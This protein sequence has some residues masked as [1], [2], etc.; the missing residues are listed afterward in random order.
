[1]IRASRARDRKL[2]VGSGSPRLRRVALGAGLA[3]ALAGCSSPGLFP[4]SGGPTSDQAWRTDGYGLVYAV[5]AGKLRTF[6]TTAVGCTPADTLDPVG[7]PGADGLL[8]YGEDGVAEQT[9]RLGGSG[10]TATA[11]V[12]GSASDIDLIPIPAVPAT[13]TAGSKPKS[14]SNDAD[15][16]D[17]DEDEDEDAAA[18]D[19]V[20]TFDVFWSTFVEN[21]NSTARKNVNWAA[22]RDQYRSKITQDT[23]SRQLFDILRAMVIPLGD[24]HVGL[25]GAGHKAFEGLRPGTRNLD[26][27]D[28]S[29]AIDKH[30]RAIGATQFLTFGQGAITYTDLPD[31]RG[32]LRFTSFEDYVKADDSFQ[33]SRAEMTRALTAV[34]TTA[35]VAALRTLVIDLRNNEGG[36]DPLTLDLAGHL[37]DR[38]YLAYTKAPR[39]DPND[40]NKFGRPQPV[41]VVPS[42][43]PRFLG[44]VHLLISDMTVSAG[45][46]FV[47][48]MMSRN[49][50]PTRIGTTTQGV[51]SDTL[52]RKL[53]NG[54]E[55][56]LGN[57]RYL[58]PDGKGFEG[59]GIP[60]TLETPT[61]TPAEMAGTQDLALDAAH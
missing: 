52:D 23:S 7:A 6:E 2:P 4:G 35:R 32:Y 20:R 3:V 13:C 29:A 57:E 18:V 39:D 46:T 34:F 27:E 55:F 8:Q 61:F 36:D 51:F 24:T 5:Q 48:A 56:N 15:A 19:P 16:D 43:G 40:P 54:W 9:L 17:E 22:L 50:V 26:T 25:T 60:P 30:L 1:M 37:T 14:S 31:G 49:P 59:S 44:P 53:P 21:Y 11:H 45:E 41:N 58:G 33:A 38:P 12:I 28:T 42:A 10:G 47:L